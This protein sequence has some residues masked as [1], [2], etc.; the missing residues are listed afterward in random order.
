[1]DFRQSE[2][3]V[4]GVNLNAAVTTVDAALTLT[5]EDSG[6]VYALNAAAGAA[7]TLP[8]AAAGLRYQFIVAAAFAT[9]N[10]TVVTATA[11]GIINGGA[12]VNGA[13]VAAAGEDS[14]NFIA[15]AET[16][17]DWIE[18]ICDGTQWIVKGQAFAAGGVT[19]TT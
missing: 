10:W 4:D 18:V 9:T 17:G 8:T 1:M 19:F 12:V 3:K 2:L 7:I 6:K 11:L 16:I 13:V 5:A 14:I 15:T